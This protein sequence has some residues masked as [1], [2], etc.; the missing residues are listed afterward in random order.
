MAQYFYNLSFFNP[1]KPET[2]LGGLANRAEGRLARSERGIEKIVRFYSDGSSA[3]ILSAE[4][5][6]EIE[7]LYKC[8]KSCTSGSI[9]Y[10]NLGAVILLAMVDVD[11]DFARGIPR[12]CYYYCTNTDTGSSNNRNTRQLKVVN[13]T[14]TGIGDVVS[15]ALLAENKSKPYYEQMV[16]MR[17]KVANGVVY[18]KVW[19]EGTTEPANWQQQI[20]DTSLTSGHWGILF[21]GY[22]QRYVAEW[23]A[24]GTDGD[25]PV[26]P[27]LSEIGGTLLLPDDTPADGYLV[28]CYHRKTGTLI[29]ETLTDEAGKFSFSLLIDPNDKVQVVAIDQLGNSWNAPFRDLITPVSS[30]E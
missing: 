24:V 7:M 9:S 21:H 8:S 22:N 27:G 30:E 14:Q 20:N 4:V 28:R 5:T 1:E 10:S 12:N 29:G 3:Y 6:D 17:L 11:G 26:V 18:C 15:N 23:L 2:L 16:Y 13:G 19:D 25:S